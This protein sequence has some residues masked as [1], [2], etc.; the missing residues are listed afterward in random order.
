MKTVA[1]LLVTAAVLATVQGISFLDLVVE[2]WKTFKVSPVT[3]KNII[4]YTITQY[5]KCF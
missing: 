2:E 1:V 5:K 3:Q 4:G